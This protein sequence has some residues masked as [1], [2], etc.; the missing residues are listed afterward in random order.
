MLDLKAQYLPLKDEIKSAL[1]DIIESGHFILGENVRSFE[2]E[3][4][5]YH[6]VNSAVAL[7]SGTDALLLSLM[8]LGVGPGDRVITTP[9]TSR[10]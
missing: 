9:Y 7:A 3:V 5:S 1:K 10:C 4:A 6:N 2:E 8:A